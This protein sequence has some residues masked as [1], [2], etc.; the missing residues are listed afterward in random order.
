MSSK[1]QLVRSLYLYVVSLI[2]L[3]MVVFSAA[4]LVNT[5]LKTWVFTKADKA[6]YYNYS[7]PCPV[8]VAKPGTTS[9]EP[10]TV[11]CKENEKNSQDRFTAQK[12]ADAVRDLSFFIVG[13]PLFLFHWRLVKKDKEEKENS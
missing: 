11:I 3:L 5:A 12:Q 10:S 1:T 4:D 7:A 13:I 8:E 9:T 6:I 2:A